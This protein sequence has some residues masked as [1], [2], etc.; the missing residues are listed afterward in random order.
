MV[1]R[2]AVWARLGEGLRQRRPGREQ[3]QLL[4]QALQLLARQPALHHVG[5]VQAVDAVDA[6]RA[7]LPPAAA[8]SARLEPAKALHVGADARP[9]LL[10][11]ARA[12][13]RV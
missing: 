2:A 3:A 4:Q 5:A 1:L 10:Q 6:Q 7:A 8:R 11:P 13:R 9:Q 12:R